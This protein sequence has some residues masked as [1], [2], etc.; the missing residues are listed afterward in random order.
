ML[1]I[2]TQLCSSLNLPPTRYITI[3]TVLL[4]NAKINEMDPTEK[5]IKKHLIQAG[6]MKKPTKE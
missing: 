6:W 1:I 5:R 3:K 4:S 2:P